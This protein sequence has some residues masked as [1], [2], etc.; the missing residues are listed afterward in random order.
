MT[1]NGATYYHNG[2]VTLQTFGKRGNDLFQSLFDLLFHTKPA[3]KTWLKEK[4][5]GYIKLVQYVGLG[6]N[7]G[8]STFK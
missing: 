1:V 8:E 4:Y 3:T 2:V 5:N 6:I 7:F